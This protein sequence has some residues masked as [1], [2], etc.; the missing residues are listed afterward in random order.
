MGQQTCQG[1]GWGRVKV[2]DEEEETRDQRERMSAGN[3]GNFWPC[4]LGPGLGIALRRALL[5][6]WLVGCLEQPGVASA[7]SEVECSLG[8]AGLGGQKGYW[9]SWGRVWGQGKQQTL[10]TCSMCC[11]LL[12]PYHPECTRSCLI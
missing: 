6:G 8:L 4:I 9:R 2:P 5:A 3:G 1:L 10:G 12:W 11:L 7:R